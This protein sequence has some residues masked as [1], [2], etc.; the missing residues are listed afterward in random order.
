MGFV[1]KMNDIQSCSNFKMDI[2][3]NELL[4]ILNTGKQGLLQTVKTQ[5]KCSKG[6]ALFAKIK[7][8]FRNRNRS[9]YR[10]SLPTTP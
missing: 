9:F 4:Y 10:I 5:M 7:T 6:S 8:I 2:F 1:H 3:S